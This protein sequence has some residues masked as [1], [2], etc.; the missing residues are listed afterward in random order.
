[1]N[2]LIVAVFL[3]LF[4]PVAMAGAMAPYT[5]T[6]AEVESMIRSLGETWSLN[7]D[8]RTFLPPVTGFPVHLDIRKDDQGPAELQLALKVRGCACQT[9]VRRADVGAGGTLLDFSRLAAMRTS[10]QLQGCY[11][12]A[13]NV[14]SR[15]LMAS[16]HD[17]MDRDKWF[18]ALPGEKQTHLDWLIRF[19]PGMR[20]ASI[21]V[22]GGVKGTPIHFLILADEVGKNA[23]PRLFARLAARH[24]LREVAQARH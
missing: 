12:Q 17:E 24:V 4:G 5:P 18:A 8:V 10:T 6:D 14:I 15:E 19:E 9:V 23:P 20:L 1:M 3:A 2:R 7:K 22:I 21:T 13:V 11:R 16:F